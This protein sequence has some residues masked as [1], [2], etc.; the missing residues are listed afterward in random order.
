MNAG[1]SA[2]NV[3]TGADSEGVGTPVNRRVLLWSVL[4]VA[5][6]QVLMVA[7]TWGQWWTV[8]ALCEL[9]VVRGGCIAG[10][11]SWMKRTGNRGLGGWL[12]MAINLLISTALSQLLHWNLLAWFNL[13]FQAIFLNEMAEVVRKNIPGASMTLFDAAHIANIECAAD[14]T[15]AVIGFLTQK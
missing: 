6:F 10:V 11:S 12:L 14:Y 5:I 9:N 3:G 2:I 4:S 7:N 13:L 15:D 8:A 1:L